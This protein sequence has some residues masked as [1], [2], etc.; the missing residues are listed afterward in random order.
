[1]RNNSL[2]CCALVLLAAGAAG[3]QVVPPDEIR[4]N[5]L[6]A[7]QQSYINDLMQVGADIKGHEFAYPFYLSR[8]LDLDEQKQKS[9]DQHSIRFEHF[10]GQTVVAVTGN[11]YASYSSTLSK[12][13]RAG[14][15]FLNVVVPVLKATVPRFEK[16]VAVQ[17]FAVEISH[18]VRTKVIGLPT[19]EPENLMVYM[20]RSAAVK[21]I[22]ARDLVGEQAAVL[23]AQVYVNADPLNLW[24]DETLPRPVM[25]SPPTVALAPTPQVEHL[26]SSLDRANAQLLRAAV[27]TERPVHS[28][29]LQP[30]SPPTVD[31]Q[32]FAPPNRDASTDALEA[33]KISS[34]DVLA[35]IVKELDTEAHFVAYAPPAFVKFRHG[36]YLELSVTTTLPEAA[37]GSRYKLAALA[38]DEHIA[39]LIRPSA[40][41]FES[42]LDFDGI[43]FSTTVHLGAGSESDNSMAAE[44]FFPFSALHCYENYD[45]TGQQLIDA[46]TVLI[47]GERASLD[48]L[49]AEA[50]TP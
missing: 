24:L 28:G 33:L 23:D 7:L 18:H 45:C 39:H 30:D 19:E 41:Y 36:V 49:R 4:E 50:G 5:D 16:N 29:P 35:K 21:L 8:K 2:R 42:T 12:G 43:A 11:Y 9:S 46:G 3:A 44:F 37:K 10:N 31:P 25:A 38:F 13:Q 32:T 22:E 14:E 47:N 48:L 26:D 15:S 6:R 1:M 34:Q 17:G 20:S 40:G 27:M